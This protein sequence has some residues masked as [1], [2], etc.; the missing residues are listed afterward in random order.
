WADDSGISIGSVGGDDLL[1]AFDLQQGMNQQ[2]RGQ[3]DKQ[4]R[5]QLRAVMDMIGPNKLSLRRLRRT[6]RDSPP[7]YGGRKA[8]RGGATFSKFLFREQARW[9]GANKAVGL[10]A[11]HPTGGRPRTSSFYNWLPIGRMETPQYLAL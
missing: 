4:C 11:P 5:R 6:D 1:S 3:S 9:P 8:E 2:P 10:A 7:T